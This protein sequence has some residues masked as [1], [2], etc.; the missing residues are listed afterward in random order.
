MKT[1]I[2][3][4][5]ILIISAFIFGC[6][7]NSNPIIPEPTNNEILIFQKDLVDSLYC[8]ADSIMANHTITLI[9]NF[10]MPNTDSL[11][12]YFLLE[13]NYIESNNTRPDFNLFFYDSTNHS[14]ITIRE[15]YQLG[16]ND[17]RYAYKINYPNNTFNIKSQT[18]V[19][20]IGEWIKV[21]NFKIYKK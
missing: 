5:F 16:R 3:I 20:N 9:D 13:S 7:K 15:F 11:I 14:R 19:F 17:L 21:K 2:T 8:T 10:I 1:I 12:I 4:L 18:I 6:D